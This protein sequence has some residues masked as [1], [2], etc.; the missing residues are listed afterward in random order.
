MTANAVAQRTDDIV[1]ELA[2]LEGP[3]LPILHAV[4]HA[5][6]F[7]PQEALPRIAEK[8][9]L[10]RAEVHGVMSFYHDFRTEPAGRHV[11][12]LCRAEACQAQGADALAAHA[13]AR[14]G[15]DFHETTASGAVTLE[16]VFCLGLC[17]CG[18]AALVDGKVVGRVDAAR[19]DQILSEMGA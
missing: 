19:L 9:N 16:P 7:V 17:A 13:K 4:Q 18:P 2:T 15:V 11:V 8:L 1:D 10:S 6:G 12:K 5:F 3:L 14:L